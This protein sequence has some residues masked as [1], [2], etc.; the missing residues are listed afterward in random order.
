M[1]L[2]PFLHLLLT[3]K[4][5]LMR[6]ALNQSRSEMGPISYG[7]PIRLSFLTLISFPLQIMHTRQLKNRN[8]I[9]LKR[10]E[11]TFQIIPLTIHS[12]HSQSRLHVTSLTPH[13]PLLFRP[14]GSGS[15]ASIP[16]DKATIFVN[17]FASKASSTL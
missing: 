1:L 8:K 2:F 14:D 6:P 11:M 3:V 5:G 15:V 4:H 12:G 13:F 7:K 9:L 17:K 16:M 10:N